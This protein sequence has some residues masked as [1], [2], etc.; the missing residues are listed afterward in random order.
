MDEAAET[1]AG[2]TVQGWVTGDV[3]QALEA[4]DMLYGDE[5]MTGY[6]EKGWWAALRGRIGEFKRAGNPTE[7]AEWMNGFGAS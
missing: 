3:A 2:N 1:A 7:L 4:L 5:F 6:D